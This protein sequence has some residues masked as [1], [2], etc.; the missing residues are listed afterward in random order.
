MKAFTYTGINISQDSDKITLNQIDYINSIKPI[1]I[2]PDRQLQYHK[3]LSDCESTSYCHL[4]GQFNWVANQSRSD[5]CFDVCQPSSTM[6]ALVIA[7]LIKVNKVLRKIKDSNL[8]SGSS[9]RGYVTFLV[10]KTML[11]PIAL[12]PKTLRRVV[13]ITISAEASAMIDALNLSYFIS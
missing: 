11:S 13:Q 9:T 4:V 10:G 6:K 8:P 5:I 12:K 2:S 3:K 7:D 1:P